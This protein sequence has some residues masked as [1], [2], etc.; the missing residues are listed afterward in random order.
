M[1]TAALTHDSR[2]LGAGTGRMTSGVSG[3]ASFLE[4]QFKRLAFEKMRTA[5]GQAA[6]L[7]SHSGLAE[8][9]REAK[10]LANSGEQVV[11]SPATL[12]EAFQFLEA[13]PSWCEPPTP[14]VE[15]S[16][17]ISFE[18]DFGPGR[19]LVLAIKGTGAIE[20]SAML[21]LGNE[22]YGTRNFA[23]RLGK[24]ELGLLAEVM[25]PES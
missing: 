21:G 10:S 25:Q 22:Q 8:S 4:A 13:L 2:Y 19:W 23:G 3:V 20:H 24:H 7:P 15:P 18:W 5:R 6:V 11:P 1:T 14:I 9:Y 16:G 17:A 12:S